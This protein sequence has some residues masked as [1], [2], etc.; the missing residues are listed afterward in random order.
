MEKN[1]S[2]KKF[3]SNQAI[4][5]PSEGNYYL[6]MYVPVQNFIY[7]KPL[8]YLVS[9]TGETFDLTMITFFKCWKKR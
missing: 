9:K 2:I 1:D 7:G 4:R 3:H 8:N 6:A 5:N